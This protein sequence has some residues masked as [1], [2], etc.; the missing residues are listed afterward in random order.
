VID[1]E[2]LIVGGGPA[3]AAT[4]IHLARAGVRVLVVERTIFPREKACSEYMSPETVRQLDRL[5]VL[6]EL[7]T[8]G[9]VPVFGTSVTAARGAR[10]EGRFDRAPIT[11]YRSAGLS[12]PRRHLDSRLLDRAR[13]AG[14]TVA[15]GT[16]VVAVTPGQ[17]GD[18]RCSLRAADQS[19]RELRPRVI[20][21][22]DGL[23]SAVRKA[24]DPAPALGWRPKRMA[25]VAHVAGVRGLTDLAE[26]HL[27][28][29]GYAGINSLGTAG[30]NVA[31]VVPMGQARA[32]AGRA[33]AF[34]HEVLE[35][36]PGTRGRVDRHQIVRPVLATGPFAVRA[37]RSVGPGIL[38]VGD[39]ADFFDPF[40]G[41][42]IY[43]ALR[44]AELAA[45]VLLDGLNRGGP[46]GPEA[47][48]PYHEA[49]RRVFG[50]KWLV[51]RM[52][53]YGMY[54]PRLFDRAVERLE[55]RGLAHTLIGVTGDFVPAGAVLNPRFLGAMLL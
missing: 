53:G 18:P 10:L 55:R 16:A 40:T 34:W 28:E 48:A 25:F 43:C 49:R 21:G 35:S 5:G 41:E 23:R 12:V 14:A 26:L 30:A 33:E 2:V 15:E 1:P 46:M 52:I 19:V 27:G 54:L 29:A 47:L 11:P 24:L 4:A 37:R 8:D 3:G 50:G 38:L 6:P 20:I 22:A 32:A 13:S 44:G 45:D 39:A 7:E 42:G 51:E 36:I 17:S 9:A 31:V